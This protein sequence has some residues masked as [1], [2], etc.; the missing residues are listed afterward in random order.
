M[1]LSRAV[2]MIW[3]NSVHKKMIPSFRA[4][5]FPTTGAVKADRVYEGEMTEPT[6]LLILNGRGFFSLSLKEILFFFGY[7]LLQ[8]GSHCTLFH[9]SL[10]YFCPDRYQMSTSY[11]RIGQLP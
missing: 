9:N 2:L 10:K 6:S 5:L 3:I 4:Y 1:T 7:I 8:S 11:S